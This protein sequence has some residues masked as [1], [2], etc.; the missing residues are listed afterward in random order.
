MRLP[1]IG[2][3]PRRGDDQPA[4]QAV[5]PLARLRQAREVVVTCPRD[6]PAELLD[7]LLAGQGPPG[8]V[9][10]L[11]SSE[12]PPELLLRLHNAGCLVFEAVVPR[13][14]LVFADREAGYALPGWQPVADPFARACALL[15]SRLGIYLLLTGQVV[16]REGASRLIWLRVHTFLEL[17]VS[18]P[19]ALPLPEVGQTVRVL[20]LDGWVGG[21]LLT[22]VRAVH[23]E[24]L[25]PEG[26][27]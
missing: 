16:R 14:V 23:V 19:P 25:V 5:D 4:A 24:H 1:V 7:L 6:L 8:R 11:A 27:M 3:W 9:T 12:A 10:V 17:W 18:I 21:S 15:W 26:A 20:A 13:Q 22:L 2:R